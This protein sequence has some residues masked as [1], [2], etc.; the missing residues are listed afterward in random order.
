MDHN[1]DAYLWGSTILPT[2]ESAAVSLIR[3]IVVMPVR[4]LEA[5][6]LRGRP[7]L[8]RGMNRGVS[9]VMVLLRLVGLAGFCFSS[10]DLQ[11]FV[12]RAPSSLS[13]RLSFSMSREK[14][15]GME[16]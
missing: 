11:H 15:S 2:G 6:V 5:H 7:R 3:V 10:V 13:A 9:V 8:C 16:A 12:A 14:V 4:L 1:M